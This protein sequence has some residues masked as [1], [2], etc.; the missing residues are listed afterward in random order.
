LRAR[1]V[2][3]DFRA[4]VADGHISRSGGSAGTLTGAGPRGHRGS[5]SRSGAHAAAAA[6]VTLAGL[7]GPA[8]PRAG[9]ALPIPLPLFT[10]P[11]P[12]PVIPAVADPISADPPD[13]VTRGTMIMVH[14]GGWAGHDAH[15]QDVLMTTPGDLLLQRGWRVVSIDYDEGTEGLQDVLSAADSELARRSGGGPL[16]LYGES[17]G[18]HLALVAASRLRA[19]DCVVG[20]GTPTDLEL[21]ESE[22]SASGDARVRLIASKMSRFFG[23]TAAEL[24][25]WDL[26]SLAPSIHADVLLMHEG[27]DAI[28]P[29]IQAARFQAARPTTQT[30]E[31]EAGDPNDPSAAFVHGTISEAG[32]AEYAAAIGS[33]V[34][35]AVSTRDA[36]RSASRTGCAQV[37]R[38]IAEVGLAVLRN[39]LR[40]L[41]HKDVGSR[42]AGSG[43]W[44]ETTL[45]MRG[46]VNAARIWTSLRGTRSG[47]RALVA[48]ARRRV[49]VA[50]LSG[51]RSRVTLRATRGRSRVKR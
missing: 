5:L 13:G 28:V 22:G 34:D 15:A 14:A 44:R 16:C 21:Y 27:D 25:P 20:L 39:A 38:S 40:C 7:L 12:P 10:K 29:A 49:K 31:L 18:A 32:R 2:T 26:V 47:R 1:R 8:A 33:L 11:R 37:G 24:A 51:D 43:A 17:A 19:I 6:A 23:T 9:A 36:G 46:E 3:V 30:V 45:S 35:R 50:V 42:S 4:M 41:A 48:T